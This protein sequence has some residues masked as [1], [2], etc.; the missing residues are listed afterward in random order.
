M[1]WRLFGSKSPPQKLKSWLLCVLYRA[2]ELSKYLPK[3]FNTLFK[4]M[5]DKADTCNQEIIIMADVN[6]NFLCRKSNECKDTL[7]LHGFKQLITKA[8]RKI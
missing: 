8:T 1:I 3:N 2:P 6:I 7:M 4:N 5:M